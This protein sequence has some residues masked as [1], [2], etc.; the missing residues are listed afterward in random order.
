MQPNFFSNVMKLEM[1]NGN[2]SVKNNAGK[3]TKF[4][5]NLSTILHVFAKFRGGN[6]IF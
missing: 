3:N 5:D 1:T 4:T 2:L 6:I